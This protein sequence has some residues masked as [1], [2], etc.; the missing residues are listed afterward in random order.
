LLKFIFKAHPDKTFLMIGPSSVEKTL[1]DELA[2]FPNVIFTG[3]KDLTELPAYLH[4]VH[5]TIIPFK[6]NTLTKSIYPLKVNE[7][8]AA[9]KPVISTPFSDDILM[10][11]GTIEI[12]SNYDEFSQAISSSIETD[13]PEKRHARQCAADQNTWEARAA[14]F[15]TVIENYLSKN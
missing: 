13:S 12:A 11:K 3:K 6:C 15:W 5:S 9:G 8:L 10:F 2:A 4:F 7:Y 1:Y 14:S